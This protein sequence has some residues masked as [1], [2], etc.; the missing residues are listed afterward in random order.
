MGVASAL[1][2]R[3]SLLVLGLEGEA[4]QPSVT[5]DT[6]AGSLS[7][8]LILSLDPGVDAKLPQCELDNLQQAVEGMEETTSTLLLFM[9]TLAGD[10]HRHMCSASSAGSHEFHAQVR[11]ACV[12]V[13]VVE[14]SSL[15]CIVFVWR[16]SFRAQS[17]C[18]SES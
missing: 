9:L 3:A 5:Q 16:H 13:D 14:P 17:C 11:M 10:A 7:L 8:G 6:T 1:L 4:V 2:E 12:A 15:S 18:I